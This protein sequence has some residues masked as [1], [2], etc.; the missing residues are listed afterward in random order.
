MKYMYSRSSYTYFLIDE[1]PIRT[2]GTL[3]S[4]LIQLTSSTFFRMG[5]HRLYARGS[6]RPQ[7]LGTARPRAGAGTQ[8]LRRHYGAVREK[9]RHSCGRHRDRDR[10]VLRAFP[11]RYGG[12]G[13][14][15]AQR[16]GEYPGGGSGRGHTSG[17]ATGCCGSRPIQRARKSTHAG[18]HCGPC[19]EFRTK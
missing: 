6:G 15:Y 18:C 7:L 3:G 4:N 13:R 1:R 8:R 11:G 17:A 9:A 10:H 5:T 14:H 2:V 12:P 19:R 16:Q